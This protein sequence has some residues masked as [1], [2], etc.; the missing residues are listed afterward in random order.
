MKEYNPKNWYWKVNGDATRVYS[1]LSGDYVPVAN[2]T[3]VAWKTDGTNPTNIDSEASLGGVLSAYYPDLTRPIPA[4]ILDGYQQGQ[5]D[6]LF[7][8]KIIKV[9]FN[10]HNRIRVLEGQSP[11]TVAQARAAIKN[12][13]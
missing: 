1:S 8:K 9:I 13:M 12:L 10:L 3:Y 11:H 4:T 6:E 5:M 7:I 2:A